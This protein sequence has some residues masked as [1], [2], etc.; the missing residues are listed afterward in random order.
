LLC[1]E[2]L[3]LNI[4]MVH[5]SEPNV[6]SSCSH[7]C[8]DVNMNLMRMQKVSFRN[9]EQ[10]IQ[11]LPDDELKLVECLRHLIYEC[12][13]DCTEHLSYNVPYFRRY[14][15]IC[16]I[17][18]A[19]V[20]SGRGKNYEGVRLGFTNGYLIRDDK[21]Y[22]DHGDRKQV[23]WKD[24]QSLKEIDLDID[25]IKMYLFEAAQIDERKFWDKRLSRSGQRQ[26]IS[27]F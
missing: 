5:H 19:S 3:Y 27:G 21:N 26:Y 2:V 12:L 15:N 4:Y 20:T 17:W 1:F 8:S 16:F 11:Y 22:L 23:Y 9:V 25:I 18:P 13:P 14:A 10:F 6:H 24:F 7:I